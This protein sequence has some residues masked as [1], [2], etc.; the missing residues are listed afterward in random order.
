MTKKILLLCLILSLTETTWANILGTDFQN[1]NPIYSGIDFVTVHSSETLEPG[2]VNMGLFLN[3]AYNTL[4]LAESIDQDAIRSRENYSDSVTGM[5]LNLGLGISKNWDFGLNFPYIV[6]QEIK[7]DFVYGR[8][9][10]TGNSEIRLNTKYKFWGNKDYGA[11]VIA[12]VNFNLVNDNPYVGEG[13]GPTYN[14]ELAADTKW[15]KVAMA[16]NIGHRWRNPGAPI[17]SYL[18]PQLNAFLAS[19]GASYLFES[20]DTKLIY[21]IY[22][23][24]PTQKREEISD[25]SSSNLESLLGIKHDITGQW[26]LHAGVT[27]EMVQGTAS[28]DWRVYTGINYTFGPLFGE[29]EATL[30]AQVPADYNSAVNNNYENPEYELPVV[31]EPLKVYKKQETF[32]LYNINFQVD[33]YKEVYGKAQNNLARLAYYAQRPPAY[34]RIV[35]SGH[36]DSTGPDDYNMLLSRRRAESIRDYLV[37]VHKLDPKKI[38]VKP[39]GETMPISDNDNYQGRKK[40]RR[41]EFTIYR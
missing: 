38:E 15:R 20:I 31:R 9:K 29:P 23:S 3:K 30:P 12:S 14:L 26:A 18:L 11:A 25:K 34:Q 4:P 37:Y 36:T 10:D 40:N 8:F 2:V 22:S 6:A 35:I 16:V 24:Y 41:V 27:K 33:S 32:V 28:P 21:E 17:N 19:F 1:F 13:A 7:S 5:D 39:Y